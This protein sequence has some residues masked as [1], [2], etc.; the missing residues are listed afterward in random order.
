MF[1]Q[2][3]GRARLSVGDGS[4]SMPA[5]HGLFES[6]EDITALKKNAHPKTK[7]AV[8]KIGGL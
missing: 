2:L 6:T 1:V 3:T 5:Y 4:P 7:K 8:E